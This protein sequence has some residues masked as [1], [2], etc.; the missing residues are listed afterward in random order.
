MTIDIGQ[1]IRDELRAQKRS[2]SWLAEQTGISQRQIQRI[3]SERKSIDTADLYRISSAMGVDFFY[4]YSLQLH[5]PEP[6]RTSQA[7]NLS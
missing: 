6:P 2:T 7:S 5:F 1:R 4:L 3:I